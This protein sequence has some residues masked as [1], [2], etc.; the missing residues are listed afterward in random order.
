MDE[1]QEHGM[2]ATADEPSLSSVLAEIAETTSET[3]E[4]QEVFERI[5]RAVHRLIPL[6]KMGV[7]RIIDGQHIALHAIS[8]LTGDHDLVCSAV[9]FMQPAPLTNWSP[10]LRPRA[11]SIQRVDDTLLELDPEFLFDRRAIEKGIRSIMWTPFRTAESIGGVWVNSLRPNAFTAAHEETMRPIA[12]LLGSAVEHWRIWD[13]E[14]RRRQRLDHIQTL[15]GTL[16]ET[17][18][19]RQ[20]FQRL[21]DG[22]QA[23]LPHDLMTLTE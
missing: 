16:A 20:I 14:R 13:G 23:V 21:S 19:V 10:R 8:V 1:R 11:G 12:A 6:D 22:M 4:M 9:E 17:L 7:V 5:A 2:T 18:D 3:L 15:L